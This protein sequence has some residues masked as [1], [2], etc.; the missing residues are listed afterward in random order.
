MDGGISADNAKEVVEAGVTIIVAGN[1]IF[2]AADPAEVIARMK[3]P[4]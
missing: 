3:N 4:K 1:A 2:G